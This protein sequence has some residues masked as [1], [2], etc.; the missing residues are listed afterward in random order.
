MKGRILCLC[1]NDYSLYY[2]GHEDMKLVY[3]MMHRDEEIRGILFFGEN[4]P[5]SF[6]GF[7]RIEHKYFTGNRCKNAYYLIEYGGEIIGWIS[8]AYNDAKIENMEI[9]IVLSAL[10]YT[11][12]GLGTRIITRLTDHASK[13]YGI[14]TFIIRPGKHNARAARAYEKSGFS[15]LASFDPNDY[16]S[17]ED[18]A[19]WGAG[20]Y[21]AEDTLNMVKTY[22]AN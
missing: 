20:D 22:D 15:V 2:A 7:M 16:Y 19:L 21:E 1:D 14:R 10:E 4:E 8:H 3:D 5:E 6:E 9:D 17:G 11:G 18:I 13:E 12:R